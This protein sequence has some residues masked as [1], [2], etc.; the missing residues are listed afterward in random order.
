MQ[1]EITVEEVNPK[2]TGDIFKKMDADVMSALLMAR[3][4][5]EEQKT[6][7]EK[8]TE[9]RIK[10]TTMPEVAKIKAAQVSPICV[11]PAK[12]K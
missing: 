12:A 10:T 9:Y 4:D 1:Q 8:F 3:A 11:T 5:I 7:L 2:T 6:M